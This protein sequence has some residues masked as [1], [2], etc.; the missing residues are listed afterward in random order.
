MSEQKRKM[1]NYAARLVPTIREKAE[2]ICHREGIS[3]NQ[4]LNLALMRQIT[5]FEQQSEPRLSQRFSRQEAQ[6]VLKEFLSRQR[7]KVPLPGDELPNAYKAFSRSSKKAP[8][9]Q[10]NG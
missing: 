4:F 2:E 5:F 7:S 1:S 6:T 3:L 8:K 10:P 9:N